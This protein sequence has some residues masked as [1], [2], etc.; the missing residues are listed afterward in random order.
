MK[1]GISRWCFKESSYS[2]I[3]PLAKSLGFDGV[4]LTMDMGGELTPETTD[5]AL[6]EIKKKAEEAGI[7]LYSMA[8]SLYWSYSLSSPDKEMREKAL[9]VAERQIRAASILGCNTVLIVPGAV[10]VDFAA[11]LGV[12]G[13]ED[14]YKYA[15][16]SAKKIAKIAEEYKVHVGM[17]NVW[18]RF[19]VTPLE[20]KYFID[21]VNSEYIGSYFDAGN[22]FPNGLPEEWIKVL[23][24]RIKKVHIKDFHVGTKNFCDLLTGSL[25]FDAVM[26]ELENIGYDDYITAE[27]GQYKVHNDVMLAHTSLA[28]DKILG[29]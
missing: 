7:E 12:T 17:E 10:K 11:G 27:M 19:L 25:D 18:N 5:E 21:E 28:M 2:E 29:R 22:V 16:E 1:K 3:F 26:K 4:E 24:N 8:S 14:A 6:L 20:M 23:G 13:Y 15:L 9:Y